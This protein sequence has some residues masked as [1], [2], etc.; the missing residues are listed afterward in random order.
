M[1]SQ[2]AHTSGLTLLL[3]L[4]LLKFLLSLLVHPEFEFHRDEFLYI[5]M[6]RHLDWGYLENPP[7][8][9]L[10][11]KLAQLLFG[12]SLFAAHFFPA[13][14]GALLVIISGLMVHELGGGRF[15]QTLAAVAYI[16]APAFLRTNTMFQPVSFDQLLWALAAYLLIRILKKQSPRRWM[17]LGVVV[18]LGLLTKYTMLLFACA[19]FASMLLTSAR[20][21]LRTKWPWFAAALAFAMWL[22]N[23][24]W[25][26]VHG[27]P[28]LEHMQ[29]LSRNQLVNVEPA[30]F[31]LMQVLMSFSASC[32]W[33]FGLYFYFSKAGQPF[34]TL[35]WI[36]V[37]CFALL[38]FL[39]GKAYYLLPAYP[40]LFAAGGCA[41][42]KYVLSAQRAWLKPA[43]LSF[44][45]ASNLGGLPYGVP[46]L[47]VAALEKYVAF[48]ANLGLAEPLRWEDGKLHRIPQ[49]YA[50][51]LGWENQAATV[52]QV[53]HSLAPEEQ[54]QCSILASNYGQAGA[55]EYYGAK[56]GLPKVISYHG[57]FY[58]W[59]PGNASQEI[60]LTVGIA[61]EDLQPYFQR[62]E[63]AGTIMHP[64][65]RENDIPILVCRRANVSLQEVWPRLAS[66]R[67]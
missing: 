2:R 39:S 62:V 64:Y 30:G 17:A 9:A 59:G 61:A 40:M 51:M 10:I 49:D 14:A 52:A 38:L 15:A 25:Q 36:Y 41:M 8:I 47:S 32:I 24:I 20:H 1:P 28:F 16:A 63:L 21:M 23:L 56:Y 54:K 11:A 66:E 67:F 65:A 29:M 60:L 34:R 19:V 31:I 4:A 33:M 48:M 53:Y 27:W 42:E 45:I 5:A 50:D 3:G 13:L 43:L 6:G 44:I 46:I 57:S 12:D 58:L 26:Y 7:M 22:P 55:L 18:G 35:G 37:V